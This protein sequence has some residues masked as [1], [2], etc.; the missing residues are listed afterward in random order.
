MSP[1]YLPSNLFLLKPPL[2]ILLIQFFFSITDNTQTLVICRAV[3]MSVIRCAKWWYVDVCF[4]V[5][6]VVRGSEASTESSGW[7][8]A[9]LSSHR[10]VKF[11]ANIGQLFVG[12]DTYYFVD[13]ILK[14]RLKSLTCRGKRDWDVW[15]W[16]HDIISASHRPKCWTRVFMLC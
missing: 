14:T 1:W 6:V 8:W 7:N 5:S 4:C 3:Y 11:T 12:G 10:Y 9:V 13:R 16:R 2:K 15:Q